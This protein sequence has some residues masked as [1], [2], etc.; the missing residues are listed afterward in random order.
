MNKR[1]YLLSIIGL[2]AGLFT[3]ASIA[4]ETP[5]PE[6]RL[7]ARPF[8]VIRSEIDSTLNQNHAR[9]ELHFNDYSQI[10]NEPFPE[11]ELSCNGVIHR[12]QLDSTLMH[13]LD[14][15]PGEYKF[16]M[17]RSG[18]YREIITDSVYIA[19][20]HKTLVGI[21]FIK[22]PEPRE[23][24][25]PRNQKQQRHGR[26]GEKVALKPVIYLYS[27]TD[28]AVDVQLT[29][30]GNFSYTYPAYEK[31]WKGTVDAK[32]GMIINKQHYHYLF[33]EGNIDGISSLVDYNEGFVV[34]N[35][36]VTAFL[37]EKLTEIGLNEQEKTDFITF[38]GPRMVDS[39]NNH[40]QFLFNE[41][42][43][44]IAT[45]SITPKPDHLFRLYML[46]TP[47][48]ESTTLHPTPQKLCNI[49][50]DGFS[51]VEWG[52]SELTFTP[53]ISFTH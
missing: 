50:R 2:L 32:G 22:N 10:R 34:S 53:D 52:G 23:F 27:P 26:P 39:E 13:V 19:P 4:L 46:W 35:E 14:V 17:T 7:I 5:T 30:K 24:Q 47:L 11:I 20:S 51:V 40:V 44:D 29:P 49:K 36:N 41:A 18:G 9:F 6:Q 37:E 31:G 1:T 15:S 16:M 42:Y 45:L 21:Y 48:P 8:H 12:F 43:D 25:A 28:L 38:W 3:L 33:W